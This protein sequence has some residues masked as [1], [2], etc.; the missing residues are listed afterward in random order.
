MFQNELTVGANQSLV[1]GIPIAILWKIR[2]DWS[3]KL[4][5]GS[6]LFLTFLLV[7]LSITR[8]A[9]LVHNSQVDD[10]W[11]VFWLT[12][13]ADLGVFLAAASAF[14][15]FFVSQKQSKSKPYIPTYIQRLKNSSNKP[16]MGSD[17]KQ[18][19][20]FSDSWSER[21]P[22]NPG[23]EHLASDGND[24]D[25]RRDDPEWHPMSS[26][27]SAEGQSGH[28]AV[29]DSAYVKKVEPVAVLP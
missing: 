12:M 16:S 29:Q 2:V 21:T 18:A 10:V 17:R 27:S 19:S 1:L 13:S 9:G 15:S 6:S 8:V 3:Q 11:E 14:R 25:R 5:L 24:F 4:A 20:I 26:T 7:A 28:S 23:F 22:T